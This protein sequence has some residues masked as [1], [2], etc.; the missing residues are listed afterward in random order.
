MNIKK[1]DTIC[2]TYWHH[3]FHDHVNRACMEY[4][5]K[6]FT[7]KIKNRIEN[8]YGHFQ[9]NLLYNLI[10]CK[11]NLYKW[12]ISTSDNC[13]FCNCTE[14]YN[15]FFITC[16]KNTRFWILIKE[17]IHVL[18]NLYLN[19][20]LE[21]I[22][23]GWNIENANFGCVN[24]LLIIASFSVYKAK[25]RHSKTDT[26]TPISLVFIFEMKRLKEILSNTEKVPKAILENK[27]HWNDLNVHLNIT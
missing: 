8:K 20:S 26:F 24:L 25:I 15:H 4:W 7:F 16:K 27:K 10:P 13:C 17:C 1:N 12:K 19:I 18:T 6:I 11:K 2:V 23:Y 5:V 9:Y 14:D 3:Y 21:H 22:I